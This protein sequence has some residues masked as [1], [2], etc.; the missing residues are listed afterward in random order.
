[1]IQDMDYNAGYIFYAV[2][3]T[4]Y[5]SWSWV[6]ASWTQVVSASTITTG[7]DNES[8]YMND[9]NNQYYIDG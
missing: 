6:S 3:L 9:Y 2:E 5:K 7:W 1:M 8:P 4:N